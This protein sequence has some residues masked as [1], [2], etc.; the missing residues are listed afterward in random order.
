MGR[1]IEGSRPSEWLFRDERDHQAFMDRLMMEVDPEAFR[2]RR[3]NG[4][5]RSVAARMLCRYAGLTQR[6]AAHVLQVGNSS[7]V[8]KQQH[9]LSEALAHN[10]ELR[11]QVSALETHLGA[12]I[13]PPS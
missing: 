10:R 4:V 6:E 2:V 13:Q 7:T 5:L 3:R 12:M 9:R 8:S 1:G 11:R